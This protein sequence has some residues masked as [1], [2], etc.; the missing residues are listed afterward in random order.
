MHSDWSIQC[1]LSPEAFLPA[2]TVACSTILLMKQSN[3]NKLNV[4]KRFLL[5]RHGNQWD[6]LVLNSS[7]ACRNNTPA[8]IYNNNSNNSNKHIV[9]VLRVG[10]DL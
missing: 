9:T 8:I 6:T 5:R 4:D 3:T 7:K 1:Q 2:I 10:W